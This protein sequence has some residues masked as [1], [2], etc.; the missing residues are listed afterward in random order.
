MFGRRGKERSQTK[1]V[2]RKRSLV[3]V[4]STSK[5]PRDFFRHPN[6]NK[7]YPQ[8]SST[9]PCS[10]DFTFMPNKSAL[11]PETQQ[12]QTPMPN[13]STPAIKRVGILKPHS[14]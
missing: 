12:I 4:P 11:Q 3:K 7:S 6:P 1:S 8:P 5:I 14:N 13:K 9:T 2:E 10:L